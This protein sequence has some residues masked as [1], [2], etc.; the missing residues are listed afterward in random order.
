V[1][2]TMLPRPVADTVPLPC[3]ENIKIS[4]ILTDSGTKTGSA[5]HCYSDHR[6]LNSATRASSGIAEEPAAELQGNSRG[7]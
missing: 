1:V 7:I 3:R 2:L 5:S 6:V 4:G